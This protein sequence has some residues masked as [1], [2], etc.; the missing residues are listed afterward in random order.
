MHFI[1]GPIGATV[2]ILVCVRAFVCV[3]VC[4]WCVVGGG[5][6]L[7]PEGYPSFS[8]KTATNFK[9]GITFNDKIMLTVLFIYLFIRNNAFLKLELLFI[10]C[11][12]SCCFLPQTKDKGVT[13]SERG[14]FSLNVSPAVKCWLA[15]DLPCINNDK[16]HSNIDDCCRKDN[17]KKPLSERSL[18]KLYC[19][20]ITLPRTELLLCSTFF[21]I[22]RE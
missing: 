19:Y 7:C 15:Q 4:V 14:C 6:N 8:P 2:E 3:C 11:K 10:T 16:P 1:S 9:V 22:F 12:A 5:H 13:R 21:F 20:C 17:L 18:Y